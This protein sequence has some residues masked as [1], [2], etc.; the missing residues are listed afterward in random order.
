MT[1]IHELQIE[2]P[3]GVSKKT[4]GAP[5]PSEV[6]PQIVHF[7]IMLEFMVF[8]PGCIIFDCLYWQAENTRDFSRGMN[9]SYL[10][11]LAKN[12]RAQGRSRRQS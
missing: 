10:L 11:E 5:S 1:T 7:L 8:L 2:I 12:A 9:P 3:P 4:E 6:A